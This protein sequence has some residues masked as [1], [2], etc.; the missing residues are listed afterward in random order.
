M[1]LRVSLVRIQR[2]R[3][4]LA[5]NSK[6]MYCTHFYFSWIL[7]SCSDLIM[8]MNGVW[9]KWYMYILQITC[10]MYA[11]IIWLKRF[12]FY[13][14]FLSTWSI[15]ALYLV[16]NHIMYKFKDT[17]QIF[18]FFSIN[19]EYLFI[20]TEWP[21]LIGTVVMVTIAMLCKEQGITVIGVCCVYEVFIA[22][23]VGT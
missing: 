7:V 9:N 20:L 21:P 17:N 4:H 8:L 15:Q 1:F 18:F 2:W 13:A 14:F 6:Y 3:W 16:L 5:K 19:F 11:P 23:R 22:Q 10:H 12:W